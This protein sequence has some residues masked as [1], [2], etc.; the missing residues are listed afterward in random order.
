[1]E[2]TNEE[3][4]KFTREDDQKEHHE[5]DDKKEQQKKEIIPPDEPPKNAVNAYDGTLGP[6]LLKD[7]NGDLIL[8]VINFFPEVRESNHPR[9][10]SR[11]G[12]APSTPRSHTRVYS[13]VYE[14]TESSE[15]PLPVTK[16]S[17]AMFEQFVKPKKTRSKKKKMFTDLENWETACDENGQT[18]LHYSVFKPEYTEKTLDLLQHGANP[19]VLDNQQQTPLHVAVKSKNTTAVHLLLQYGA[20]RNILNREGLNALHIAIIN[21]DA[22]TVAALI[23]PP[24]NA[25][26][27]T[28]DGR[29][30]F[31][32]AVK[33]WNTKIMK[34]LVDADPKLDV[35]YPD[36]LGQSP[37]S[38][39]DS[40]DKTKKAF[41]DK[42]V[43]T[44]VSPTP[45]RRPISSK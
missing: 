37:E 25:G 3:I 18:P 29:S 6:R 26:V 10:N 12:T 24:E 43:K 15:D 5:G 27:L 40:H 21:G 4:N 39:F 34:M 32:L 2:S 11:L 9:I 17:I 16:E 19:N 14:G 1:M 8:P 45:R 13:P 38:L 23:S 7:E 36:G 20:D 35:T 44:E 33:F 42:L 22:S 31:Y 30:P 41:F 28:R